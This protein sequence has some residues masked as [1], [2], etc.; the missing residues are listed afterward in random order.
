[1]TADTAVAAMGAAVSLAADT[2]VDTGAGAG[3]PHAAKTIES[4]AMIVMIISERFILRFIDFPP[5]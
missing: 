1:L 3:V 2:A 4:M 5:D